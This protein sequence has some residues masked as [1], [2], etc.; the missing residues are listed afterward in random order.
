MMGFWRNKRVL[1][2]GHTG[3]KGAWLALWLESLGAE[4]TGFSL[5]PEGTPNLYTLLSPWSFS[6]EVFGDL[7]QEADVIRAVQVSN[8]EIVLHLAAQSLVRRS[9]REPLATFET[10]VNGTLRLLSALSEHAKPEVVLVVTSDKVYENDESGKAFQE[11]DALGGDDPYSASKACAEIAVGSW[12]ASGLHSGNCI[13]ATARAGNV[14]GGGDW[15]EDRLIPD[16]I[17]AVSSKQPFILRNPNSVRPWQHVL[18]VLQG[19]LLYA[20]KLAGQPAPTLALNFGPGTDGV[21]TTADLIGQLQKEMN[22]GIETELAEVAGHPEKVY[23]TLDVSRAKFE[24]GW[25]PRLEIDTA[26]KWTADWYNAWLEGQNMREVSLQQ[27]ESY[28]GARV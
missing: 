16:Y 18:D 3:F 13:L 12:R 15:A 25:Q 14:I 20:E 7:R 22:A 23:L 19:Y 8:P 5:P 2:T 1:L 9:Y 17:R 21:L 28:Q 10:N 24:I 11:G 26:V 4:V 27:I 6:Q